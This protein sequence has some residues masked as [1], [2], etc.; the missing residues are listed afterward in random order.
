[1]TRWRSGWHCRTTTG[2]FLC[3]HQLLPTKPFLYGICLL[4]LCLCG[5]P[6]PPQMLTLISHPVQLLIESL[7]LTRRNLSCVYAA[8]AC[9]LMIFVLCFQFDGLVRGKVYV[10]VYN[11]LVGRIKCWELT[12]QQATN[13]FTFEC[14]TPAMYQH[15]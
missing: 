5:F 15:L 4:S 11:I 1:M 3:T 2:R 8:T 14:D 9:L 13:M 10:L 6:P 7:S 12:F